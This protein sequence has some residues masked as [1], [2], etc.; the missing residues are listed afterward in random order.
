MKESRYVS[1]DLS[2]IAQ[3]KD[4]AKEPAEASA[5][6]ANEGGRQQPGK[7]RTRDDAVGE[8][9]YR[10]ACDFKSRHLKECRNHKFSSKH[11][12]AATQVVIEKEVA[13]CDWRVNINHPNRT[14]DADESSKGVV[15]DAKIAEDG[16]DH[17]ADA[18]EE[19]LDGQ[20]SG[21][22]ERQQQ[23]DEEDKKKRKTNARRDCGTTDDD[24]QVDVQK[25]ESSVVVSER[26]AAEP[27][28]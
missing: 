15:A 14:D 22:D 17:D 2:S 19:A 8:V 9:E 13:V 24:E 25:F 7:K 4:E 10:C 6:G 12:S 5:S 28:I 27:K 26:D 18:A 11:F 21:G 20:Y 1:E 16:D 3:E 23:E